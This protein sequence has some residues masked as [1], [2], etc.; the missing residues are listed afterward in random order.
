MFHSEYSSSISA[1]PILTISYP[2]EDGTG[3]QQGGV[4]Q[5]GLLTPF[6]F[7]EETAHNQISI[8]EIVEGSSTYTVKWHGEKMIIC[9]GYYNLAEAQHYAAIWKFSLNT[10]PIALIE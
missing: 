5:L 10:P 7:R 2:V 6:L 4:K 8:T 9:G 3:S 1:R